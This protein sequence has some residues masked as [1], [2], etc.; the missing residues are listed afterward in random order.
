ME[1]L[2]STLEEV[3][4]SSPPPTPQPPA[5]HPAKKQASTKSTKNMGVMK[6]LASCGRRLSLLPRH[7]LQKSGGSG[8]P[9][10]SGGRSSWTSARITRPTPP[11]SST[12]SSTRVGSRQPTPLGPAIVLFFFHVL[13][14]AFFFMYIHMLYMY[15]YAIY[16]YIS[17][18]P[19]SMVPCPP[20]LP[21]RGKGSE[22]W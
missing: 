13:K 22:L 18:C 6:D 1:F 11:R 15:M 10:A 17:T 3:T 5:A 8:A 19:V 16:I 20:P 21:G 12:L 14:R 4:Q 7:F 9:G 2:S